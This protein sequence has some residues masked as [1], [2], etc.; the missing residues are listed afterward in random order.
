MGMGALEQS[1]ILSSFTRREHL[2]EPVQ[3][4]CQE[5]WWEAGGTKT[6]KGGN[7]ETIEEGRQH[8]R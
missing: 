7:T 4:G 2:G 3:R 8:G 5:A 6:N 1:S